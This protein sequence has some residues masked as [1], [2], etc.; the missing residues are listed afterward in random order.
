V[1]VVLSNEC[2]PTRVHY[3]N[4]C[5]VLAKPATV[6]VGVPA[7]L[8]A[9]GSAVAA[10]GI[11]LADPCIG[12]GQ[13]A[14]RAV[15][16]IRAAVAVCPARDATAA[17][18]IVATDVVDAAAPFLAYSF[19]AVPKRAVIVGTTFPANTITALGVLA[20]VVIGSAGFAE[21]TDAAI[22]LAVPRAFTVLANV[23]FCRA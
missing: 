7:R 22:P 12:R 2:N 1:G 10:L 19:L 14:L 4:T 3:R 15:V 5:S 21:E 8:D 17:H 6:P 9:N 18:R 11:R 23:A 20:I 16:G 13:D